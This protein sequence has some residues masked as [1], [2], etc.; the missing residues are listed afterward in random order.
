MLSNNLFNF[1]KSDVVQS[2]QLDAGTY[3]ISG[4]VKILEEKYQVSLF[5]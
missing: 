2:G 3:D 4:L 5:L 1:E